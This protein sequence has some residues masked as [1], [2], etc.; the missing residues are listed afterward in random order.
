MRRYKDR[1]IEVT[2]T[3]HGFHWDGRDYTSLT[4]VA[5]AVTGSRWSGRVFFGL[6]PR[7]RKP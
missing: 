1:V 6:S 2:V 5:R 7:K 4:A 3:A